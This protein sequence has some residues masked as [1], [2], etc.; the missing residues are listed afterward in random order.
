MAAHLLSYLN[1][2]L[3]YCLF[4]PWKPD[5][6]SPRCKNTSQSQRN[7]MNFSSNKIAYND[8]LVFFLNITNYENNT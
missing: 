1:I 2:K 4:F 8:K 5:L 3:S 7:E 6:I